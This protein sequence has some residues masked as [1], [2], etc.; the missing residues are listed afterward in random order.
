MKSRWLRSTL[1]SL[2]GLAIVAAFG[3][4]LYVNADRYLQLFHLSPVGLAVLFLLSLQVPVLNGMQNT[5]LYRAL[6]STRFSH[7]T[8]FLLAAATSL[9]NQ[10]PVPGGIVS[11]GFYLK[12]SYDLSYSVFTSSTISFFI[13]FL[14]LDGFVGILILLYWALFRSIV[15]ASSLWIGFSIMFACMLVFWLPVHRLRLPAPIQ[16]RLDRALDGWLIIRRDPLLVLKM[17]GLQLITILL[18][19]IRYWLAFHMFSQNVT[20][21]DVLLMSNA[22]ILTQMVSLA[23]GGLGVREAIVGAVASVLGFGTAVSV[24]AVGLD[25]LVSTLVIFA[26]G[27]I[28]TVILGRQIVEVPASPADGTPE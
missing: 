17:L 10:L 15:A 21:A 11:R 20:V 1:L 2:L 18:V 28:S 9:A 26:V 23:P 8:G 6:G 22:T 7:R 16:A 14:S 19:A 4:Y 13:C 3:Y 12:R 5:L 24:A 27:G 25:R